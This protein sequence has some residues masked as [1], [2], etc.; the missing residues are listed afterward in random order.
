MSRMTS[1]TRHHEPMDLLKGNP[2]GQQNKVIVTFYY[3]LLRFFANY[4]HPA[5]IEGATPSFNVWVW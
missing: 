1:L 4:R 3:E 5:A 2:A